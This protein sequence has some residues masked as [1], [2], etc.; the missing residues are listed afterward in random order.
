[1]YAP[2][3]GRVFT[4]PLFGDR[5]CLMFNE[6]RRGYYRSVYC[7]TLFRHSAMPFWLP[8]MAVEITRV[9]IAGE[10]YARWLAV[11]AC[12]RARA[13]ASM[14]LRSEA[15]AVL[16]VMLVDILAAPRDRTANIERVTM[17]MLSA[18][19]ETRRTYY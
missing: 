15:H 4:R 16:Y 17:P 10:C 13:C 1:M 6:T 12:V 5:L 2:I 9:Y 7:L 11:R 3:F 18:I 8:Y 14:R 19:D